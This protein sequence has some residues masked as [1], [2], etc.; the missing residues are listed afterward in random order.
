MNIKMNLIKGVVGALL[1]IAF[2]FA[3]KVT[4]H[5]WG[6][7]GSARI[8]IETNSDAVR[9]DMLQFVRVS[10]HGAWNCD[11]QYDYRIVV[12]KAEDRP[13]PDLT[14]VNISFDVYDARGE[15]VTWYPTMSSGP[16]PRATDQ[17]IRINNA[18]VE[19]RRIIYENQ[20]G[21]LE[22]LRSL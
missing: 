5:A 9:F 21:Y 7:E 13:G 8:C 15:I 3:P 11:S 6:G 22:I 14:R 1:L 16:Y 4:P 17:N 18:V 20:R 12:M 10:G 2:F 19:I